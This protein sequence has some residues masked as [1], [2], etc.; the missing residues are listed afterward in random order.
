MNKPELYTR[1]ALTRN[2]PTENLVKGDIAWVVEYLEHPENGEE[3]AILEVFN[4]IGESLRIVTV[5]VSSIAALRA[6][7]VPALRSLIVTH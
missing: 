7:Q 2:L 6:D 1:V 5:P 4:A 3:G